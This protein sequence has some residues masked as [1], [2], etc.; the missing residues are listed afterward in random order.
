MLLGLTGTG[1]SASANT[2][3][4][5]AG[6]LWDPTQAFR[7][8]LSSVPV[9]TRC[10]A[11]TV[12]FFKKKVTVV[13]T[14]DFLN[15]RLSGLDAQTDECRSYCELRHSAVLLVL[16]LGRV[17]DQEVGILEKLENKLGLTIRHK[18]VV[19]LTHG[20]DFNGKLKKFIEDRRPLKLLVEACGNRYH[21]FKNTSKDPRQVLDLVKKFP[22]IDVFFPE[23]ARKPGF[24]CFF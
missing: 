3:L 18:T 12:T 8:G 15:E 4:A 10:E 20:E 11:K 2:I 6:P 17:T 24:F 21:V 23:L 1:K 9:T 5:A 14:P 22:D 19:L 16:Q 7:S 13:D